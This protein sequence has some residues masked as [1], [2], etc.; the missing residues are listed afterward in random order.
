MPLPSLTPTTYHQ[1]T[2]DLL[3]LQEPELWAWFA[4]DRFSQEQA[5]RVRLELLKSTYRLGQ[6]AHPQL[7]ALAAEVMDALGLSLPLSLYQ[8]GDG[9][10]MNAGLCFV[11]GELH[12]VL[13][14]PVLTR[15]DPVELRSLLGHELAHHCLWT[16]DDGSFRVADAL[17]ESLAS[18]TSAAPSWIQL[19]LRHRRYTELFADRGSLVANGGDH[20]AAVRC[21]LKVTTG[22]ESPDADAYLR[23]VEEVLGASTDSSVAESHP[24]LFLRAWAMGRWLDAREAADAELGLR[25]EGPL[26]LETLDV[27][28][29]H[30]LTARTLAL[31]DA[32]LAPRWMQTEAMMNQAAGFLEPRERVPLLPLEFEDSEAA[33][34]VQDYLAYVLLDLVTADPE[35]DEVALGAALPFAEAQGF[36]GAFE[37][38]VRKELKMTV[39]A[40]NKRRE[41]WPRLK[42]SL[43][44]E[45]VSA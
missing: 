41:D 11:P 45:E 37:K 25:I 16:A 13:A 17:L 21:L 15:L 24:E 6:A 44:A 23:Q 30:Q 32:F 27:L 18:R 26:N 38:V 28:G 4:S 1:R 20:L 31:V 8:S 5:Q 19:A 14:G 42:A 43:E 36:G 2:R 39:A 3:R 35:L 10:S 34:S 7:H 22:A 40:L 29:Q 9:A 33:P 12:V